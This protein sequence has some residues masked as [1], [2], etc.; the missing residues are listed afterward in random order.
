MSFGGSCA[1]HLPMC[2]EEPTDCAVGQGWH[3]RLGRGIVGQ[4][5]GGRAFDGR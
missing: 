5:A 1:Q 2:F 3:S 4:Q